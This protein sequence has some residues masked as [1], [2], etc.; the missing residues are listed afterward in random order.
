MKKTIILAIA[1]M[2]TGACSIAQI[3]EG[4]QYTGTSMD[5]LQDNQ[6]IHARL[7]EGKLEVM[8]TAKGEKCVGSFQYLDSDKS[9][10]GFTTASNNYVGKF[11]GKFG[12]ACEAAVGTKAGTEITVQ[13]ARLGGL[14]GTSIMSSTA[15]RICED[16]EGVCFPK[17]TFKV[18]LN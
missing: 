12:P 10:L 13:V 1:A 2:F 5:L 18:T 16:A 9:Y 7:L 14:L 4:E 17:N 11:K 3:Q 6:D 15:I 8:I